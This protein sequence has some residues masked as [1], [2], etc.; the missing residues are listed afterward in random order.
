MVIKRIF[1]KLFAY[2]LSIFIFIGLIVTIIILL[3]SP[4]NS[5]RNDTTPPIV[6]IN[7]PNEFIYHTA[8]HLLN[9]SVIDDVAVDTIWYNFSEILYLE[10]NR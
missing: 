2:L 10:L 5:P 4:E 8:E 9:I 7:S 1:S 3:P 6:E